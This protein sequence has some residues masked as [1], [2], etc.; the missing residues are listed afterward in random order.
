MLAH[1]F[2]E[3]A[4]QMALT[5]S[6][7]EVCH[8]LEEEEGH[9]HNEIHGRSTAS[10]PSRLCTMKEERLFPARLLFRGLNKREP[11]PKKD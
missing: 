5:D 9:G 11:Y 1:E 4:E 7:G 8:V 3:L 6:D 10:L 2:N